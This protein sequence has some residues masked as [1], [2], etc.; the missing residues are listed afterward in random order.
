MIDADLTQSHT[1]QILINKFIVP[2]PARDE[3]MQRLRINRALIQTLSG[4]V[5]DFIFEQTGGPGKYNFV[6]MAVW[7]SAAALDA[8]RQAV[9]AEYAASGY[10]PREMYARLDIEADIA[11]YT[12]IEA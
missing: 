8:A 3:F 12:Q 2:E 7:E 4:F 9:Y 6:T 5:R 11:Y 10:N 1:Q